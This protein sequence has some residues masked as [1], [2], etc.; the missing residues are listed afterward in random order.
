MITLINNFF[1]KKKQKKTPLPTTKQ[2]GVVSF[3]LILPIYLFPEILQVHQ[4]VY[5]AR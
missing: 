3:L 5:L 2:K 4:T 1:L